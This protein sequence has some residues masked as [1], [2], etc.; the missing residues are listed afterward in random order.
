LFSDLETVPAQVIRTALEQRDAHRAPERRGNRR[1]VAVK[2]LILQGPRAGRDDDPATGQQRWH[3]VRER[4][5]G[6]R[7]RFDD[8]LPAI[9]K[10]CR[11]VFGHGDLLQA[12]RIRGQRARQRSVRTE[13]VSERRGHDVQE[14]V[15][16]KR[17]SAVAPGLSGRCRIQRTCV[18]SA[19]DFGVPLLPLAGTAFGVLKVLPPS[20][21]NWTSQAGPVAVPGW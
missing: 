15:A 5:A 19:V 17:S 8:Q 2:E 20:L 4:L 14:N 7:S 1:Q 10:R 21:E 9:F 11:D 16:R 3:E 13:D 6:A 12:R 18:Y